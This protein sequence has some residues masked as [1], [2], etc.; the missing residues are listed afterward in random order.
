[1]NKRLRFVP[2]LTMFNHISTS[3][4]TTNLNRTSRTIDF[5][6]HLQFRNGWPLVIYN[7]SR[8]C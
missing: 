7:Q 1:M 3:Y 2:S 8:I 4:D 6:A 5:V